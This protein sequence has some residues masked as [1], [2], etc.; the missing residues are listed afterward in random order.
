MPPPTK[1]APRKPV[2]R[3]GQNESIS[4][5]EQ[6]QHREED[7]ES[8]FV[9][10]GEEDRRWDPAEYEN[11]EEAM[12]W[13]ASASNA[14]HLIIYLVFKSLTKSRI[15]ASI[16]QSETAAHQ[17]L[18]PTQKKRSV[19]LDCPQRKESHRYEES[20]DNLVRG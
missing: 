13:D 7:P 15:P 20:H 2:R 18:V 10:A 5:P 14:S 17:Q 6:R 8:L 11:D 3:L 12:V 9:P 4:A 19:Q 1:P 16:R